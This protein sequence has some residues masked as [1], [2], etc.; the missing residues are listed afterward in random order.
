MVID[1]DDGR[2][3]EQTVVGEPGL[4]RTVDGDQDSL[5]RVGGRLTQQSVR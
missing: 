4:L 1:V 3:I 5:A 2:R